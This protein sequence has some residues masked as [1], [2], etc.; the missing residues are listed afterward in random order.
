MSRFPLL[1]VLL[2]G[3]ALLLTGAAGAA[4]GTYSA[5]V[6]PTAVRPSVSADYAIALHSQGNSEDATTGDITIPAGFSVDPLTLS[7]SVS[8]GG[9]GAHLWVASIDPVDPSKID[10]DPLLSGDG[11]CKGATLTVTFT[12]TSAGAEGSYTWTTELFHDGTPFDLSGDQPQTVVDGTPPPSPSIDS[13]PGSPTNQTGANFT[14]SDSEGAVSFQCQLDGG[15]F[16]A[17]S[18]PKSYSVADG[19]HT[20]DVKAID[21][22]GNESGAASTSWM[23]DTVAPPEP[24]I[25]A[26]APPGLTTQTSASFS[27]SDTEGGVAFRCQLDGQGFS[28]CSPPA[29]Y[30]GLTDGSH[31]F[32]VRAVDAASNQS[33]VASYTWTIDTTPPPPPQITSAPQDPSGSSSASFSFTDA[34]PTATFRCRLDGGGFSFC[35]SPQPYSNLGDGEH[36]FDVKAVDPL[37][38]ESEVESYTWTIDTIHPIVTLTDKPPLLTNQTTATFSFSSNKPSS[39]YEC[40]LDGGG[41]GS[42][43]SPRL[44]TGLDDG[45]HTFSVRATSLGNLGLTTEYTWTV[46]TVAPATSITSTPPAT[47]N[48]ASANFTFASSEVGSTFSCG[49][50]A[51]GFTPCASPKSYAGLGDGTH[52]FRVQAIDAAG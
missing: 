3:L 14:F 26:G 16:S 29:G 52:T 41:F 45:S 15:G 21:A 36:A 27:F 47:S 35:V 19:L 51:G 32:E 23:V 17:C 44:Y 18:S 1:V 48:S 28:P 39:T 30:A 9:C 49:L 31:T 11:L 8:G 24:T 2:T 7:A 4:P 42:C 10:L 25:D 34:D 38:H 46:D 6:S 22:A 13:S 12:A 50:D 5:L 40:K 43:T 20:F 37:G 33:G